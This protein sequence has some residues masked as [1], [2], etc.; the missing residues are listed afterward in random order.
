M[1]MSVESV[2]VVAMFSIAVGVF[3]GYSSTQGLSAGSNRGAALRVENLVTSLGEFMKKK[4]AW[5]ILIAV[6]AFRCALTVLV[7]LTEIT[8]AQHFTAKVE[9]G[10]RLMTWSRS[11]ARS[12]PSLPSRSGRRFRDH[13]EAQCRF[14]PRVHKGDVV[15]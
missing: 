1:Q 12:T 13:R 14:Q 9:R 2:L 11:L 5:L 10:M 8:P 15:L 7:S 4:R 6:L 3:F